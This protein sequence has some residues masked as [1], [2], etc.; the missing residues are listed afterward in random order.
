MRKTLV[1]FI[2]LLVLLLVAHNIRRYLRSMHRR[3]S[4]KGTVVSSQRS[5]PRSL[6]SIFSPAC[7]RDSPDV[8]AVVPVNYTW[9]INPSCCRGLTRETD[10]LRA[11]FF[12]H[13]YK[14]ISTKQIKNTNAVWS[15]SVGRWAQTQYL[16]RPQCNFTYRDNQTIVRERCTV[17][18]TVLLF[19]DSLLRGVAAEVIA[20]LG[21]FR[22]GFQWYAN[23][24]RFNHCCFDDTKRPIEHNMTEILLGYP[25]GG[26]GSGFGMGR[27]L[28]DPGDESGH[29]SYIGAWRFRSLTGGTAAQQGI[30]T[31][32]VGIGRVDSALRE[33]LRL[34]RTTRV[35]DSRPLLPP[36]DTVVY[37]AGLWDAHNTEAELRRIFVSTVNMIREHLYDEAAQ[38]WT[39]KFVWMLSHKQVDWK[40]PAY[41]VRNGNRVMFAFNRMLKRWLR[42]FNIPFVDAF[43]MTF[44]QEQLTN[45]GVHY[46]SPV[47]KVKAQ[48]VMDLVCM[49]LDE[50]NRLN[51][52]G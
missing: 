19:G 51:A 22:Y 18:R 50:F 8:D 29:V 28:S 4:S 16:T 7:W 35:N 41:I 42:E 21:L 46:R 10:A 9:P 43:P 34:H 2:F 44:G 26:P 14:K 5:I 40:K 38:R 23:N 3:P 49:S 30:L 32:T 11:A 45:D 17:N 24:K 36:L 27:F 12:G 39:T 1:V 52:P 25:S 13:G 33:A 6:H 31:D 20:P 15:K 48:I 47:A 37:G